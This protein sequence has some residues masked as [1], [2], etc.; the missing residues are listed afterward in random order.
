MFSCDVRFA[1]CPAGS[2]VHRLA[3]NN[4]PDNSLTDNYEEVCTCVRLPCDQTTQKLVHKLVHGGNGADDAGADVDA[5]MTSSIF[6]G[7]IWHY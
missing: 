1:P 2:Y 4:N 5:V 7:A 6:D 3:C